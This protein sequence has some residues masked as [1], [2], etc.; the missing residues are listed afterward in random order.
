MVCKLDVDHYKD[1]LRVC[2]PAVASQNDHRELLKY[3]NLFIQQERVTAYGCNAYQISKITVPC[4]S[5]GVSIFDGF[6]LLIPPLKVIPHTK[7]VEIH[8]DEEKREYMIIFVDA[9]GDDLGATTNHFVEGQPMDYPSFFEMAQNNFDKC[10]SDGAGK[11]VIFVNPKYLLAAMEG[12]KSAPAVAINFANPYEFFSVRPL[13]DSMDAMAL[14]LPVR[15]F[16]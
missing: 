12:F 11:Y 3:I 7:S 5:E 2:G 16:D 9:E 1:I 8:I 6:N 10:S 14:V 4:T 15:H 13:N